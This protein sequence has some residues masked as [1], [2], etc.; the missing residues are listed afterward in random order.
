MILT[1]GGEGLV[2]DLVKNVSP[3]LHAQK[4]ERDHIIIDSADEIL[5]NKLTAIVDRAE[6]RDLV[7]I[8]LLERAGYSIDA[9]LPAALAKD[10]GCTPA[11]LACCSPS[12]SVTGYASPPTASATVTRSQSKMLS[13]AQ[14]GNGR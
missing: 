9:A 7:V 2:I 11:T 13:R 10:G 4:L 14:G 1:R 5:A 8:M 12:R 3:Q 6:E